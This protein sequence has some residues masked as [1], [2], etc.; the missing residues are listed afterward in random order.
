MFKTQNTNGG[1]VK[2]S[3]MAMNQHPL[4]VYTNGDMKTFKKKK[5]TLNPL[6]Q[7]FGSPLPP[8]TPFSPK[9]NFLEMNKT[10]AFTIKKSQKS[11]EP[12]E[13]N[14]NGLSPPQTPTVALAPKMNYGQDKTPKTPNTQMKSKIEV[15]KSS[16]AIQHI[17]QKNHVKDVIVKKQKQK[18]LKTNQQVVD[19]QMVTNSAGYQLKTKD[20]KVS[21]TDELKINI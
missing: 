10:N 14:C 16:E 6:K 12:T 5:Q 8:A 20:S 15:G 19:S 11:E 2:N 18:P 17:Y 13:L 9:K 3:A 4:S 1:W 7:C 21:K